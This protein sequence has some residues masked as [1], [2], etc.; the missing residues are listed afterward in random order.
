MPY[1]RRRR[2]PARRP[3]RRRPV[4]RRKPVYKR[5]PVIKKKFKKQVTRVINSLAESKYNHVTHEGLDRLIN[6]S[7]NQTYTSAGYIPNKQLMIRGFSYTDANNGM[8]PS[9]ILTDLN[10]WAVPDHSRFKPL[11]MDACFS[12]ASATHPKNG[13]EGSYMSPSMSRCSFVINVPSQPWTLAPN[14][15]SIGLPQLFRM[16]VFAPKES[17][18]NPNNE[19][20][21]DY[22][23]ADKLFLDQ[24]GENNGYLNTTQPK[25]TNSSNLLTRPINKRLFRVLKDTSFILQTPLRESNLIAGPDANEGVNYLP[26]HSYPSQKTISVS[27]PKV[28]KAYYGP[29]PEPQNDR[30]YPQVNRKQYYVLFLQTAMTGVTTPFQADQFEDTYADFAFITA[31]PISTFK[32]L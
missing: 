17:T 3:M 25:A 16:I 12:K 21:D 31:R 22:T 2:P 26:T 15:R 9:S 14:A 19:E 24:F 1:L 10:M 8:T 13:I 29:H 7:A 28:K 6:I 11:N 18:N 5:K 23:I 32:D 4:Y 20:W 30:V 27:F